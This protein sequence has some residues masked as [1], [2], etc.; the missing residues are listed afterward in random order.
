M[1]SRRTRFASLSLSGVAFVA[2]AG[3]AFAAVSPSPGGFK[4]MD[5]EAPGFTVVDVSTSKDPKVQ[6]DQKSESAS[7]PD[8]APAALKPGE[9]AGRYSLEREAGKDAGCLLILGQQKAHGSQKASL[10]PGCKD[11][12]IMIFDPVGWQLVDGRLVLTARRGHLAHFDRQPDGT[13]SKDP[14][15]GKPLVLKKI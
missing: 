5:I 4:P 6:K 9:I 7:S 12:G 10:A 8:P 15:E 1:G 2:L 3:G 14:H 13:W 11:Q